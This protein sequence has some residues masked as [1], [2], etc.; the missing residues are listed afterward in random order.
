MSLAKTTGEKKSA[1]PQPLAARAHEPNPP[2]AADTESL[3]FRFATQIERQP[4]EPLDPEVRGQ[5]E[6]G[7]GHPFS[8]VRI[9]TDSAAHELASSMAARAFTAGDHIAFE[10]GRYR[11]NDFGGL[12][13]LAH[14]LAH[15]AQQSDGTASPGASAQSGSP[16]SS[17]LEVD[18]NRA[19][20]GALMTAT[21][22]YAN[23]SV[24]TADTSPVTTGR[25]EAPAKSTEKTPT[26]ARPAEARR[27]K[28]ERTARVSR[29]RQPY[30]AQARFTNYS[31]F[32]H[33][34]C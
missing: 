34:G 8:Q 10:S 30:W 24:A 20:A 9:H 5:M 32:F 31:H 22:C 18:A 17:L 1:P 15:V 3:A 19:A 16:Q 23:L 33:G 14:E 6:K 12:S 29:H 27:A 28:P 21:P 11:T 26:K 25:T 4:G 13:L 2:A 7:L